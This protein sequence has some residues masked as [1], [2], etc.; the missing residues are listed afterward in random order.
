MHNIIHEGLIG[1]TLLKPWMTVNK[2]KQK[3]KKLKVKLEL[4]WK[5]SQNMIIGEKNLGSCYDYSWKM[6]SL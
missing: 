6:D 4:N 5:I 3:K 1:E 2:L